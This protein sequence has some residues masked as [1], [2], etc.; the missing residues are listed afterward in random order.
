MTERTFKDI[1][2]NVQALN[3]LTNLADKEGEG[4]VTDSSLILKLVR[5]RR[6]VTPIVETWDAM[7]RGMRRKYRK[8]AGTAK[9]A[10]D[11]YAEADAQDDLTDD[12]TAAKLEMIPAE[13]EIP[14]GLSL[15][16]EELSALNLTP[17]VLESLVS[18]GFLT[19]PK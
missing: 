1:V 17:A 11:A 15:K 4:K 19:L 12:I 10:G 7:E 5:I 14:D 9:K 6:A 16:W 13:L 3:V 2:N 18:S 8:I